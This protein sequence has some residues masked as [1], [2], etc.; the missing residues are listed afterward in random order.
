VL[1]DFLQTPRG[2]TQIGFVNP[3]DQVVIRN[4]GLPGTDYVQKIYQLGCSVCGYVYGANGADIWDRKCPKCQRGKA[5]LP[6]PT[7]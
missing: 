7:I 5:G 1:G 2:T 6:L 4:T 3:N